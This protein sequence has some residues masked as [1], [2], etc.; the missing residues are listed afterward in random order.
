MEVC[1]TQLPATSL[2]C[3]CNPALL[4]WTCQTGGTK[5]GPPR[6]MFSLMS[7]WSFSMTRARVGTGVCRHAGN[8]SLA[9]PT[10]A[11]NSSPVVCGS[12]EMTSCVACALAKTHM[13]HG[14]SLQLVD[15][16]SERAG[17]QLH[18]TADVICWSESTDFQ[19]KAG[20]GEWRSGC[21]QGSRGRAGFVTSIQLLADDSVNSPLMKFLT[22]GCAA[23]TR[24]V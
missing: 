5:T 22:V 17:A 2:S 14:C 1:S 12:R 24:H 16:R 10:A 21:A 4:D 18:D 9:A 20:M 23:S 7:C 13:P 8:A 3:T 19:S 11:S 6:T 15:Q